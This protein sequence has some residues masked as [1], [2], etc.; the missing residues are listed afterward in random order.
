MPPRPL[1]SIVTPSYNAAEFIE[2]TI[3]S[4][5]AQD[6]PRIEYLVMDGGST[7]GTVEILERYR[8]RLQ[9]VSEKDRG[10]ADAVNRGFRKAR[11]EILAWIG[12]DD[13]YL[14]GAVSAAV[15]A[16]TENP[17][18]GAVYGGGYW[19]DEHG[20]TLGRY[21]TVAP[22]DP[23]MFR[24]ECPI[25]QPAC[26]MRRKAVEAIGGL[27]ES[28]QSAFDY[29][30]WIRLSR[31]HPFRAIPQH[32]AESRMH[33]RNKSLGQKQSMFD[34]CIGLLS[35]HYGYVPMHWVYS[36]V[37]F[38]RDRTDQFFTPMRSSPAAYLRTLVVG[39]RYNV[40]HLPRFWKEWLHGLRD[41]VSSSPAPQTR[42]NRVAID[43]TPMLPGGDNGG[44]KLL[45]LEL[46]RRLA[47]R[48]GAPELVLLTSAKSH[49][50]LAA[51][52]GPNVRRVCVQKSTAE[53]RSR[54]ATRGGK[55]L[56]WFSQR[57]PQRLR[58]SAVNAL[59]HTPS[60]TPLLRQLSADLLFCPFTGISFFDPAVPI[61]AV[62]ADLQYAYYPEFFTPEDRRERQRNF[63]QVCRVASRVVCISEFTRATVLEHSDLPPDRT[64]VI[65]IP[66]RAVSQAPARVPD[67]LP[68]SL[69]RYLLYP[70]NFWRHKN[71]ELLLIA[72]GIYCA[73]HPQPDLKLVLTGA[74]SARRDELIEATGRMGLADRVVFPGFL[75]EEDFAALLAGAAAM[76]FPSLFEGF[77]MPV[78]E[79]MAAGVPVLCANLTSLP[80]V[81]APYAEQQ[82]H[83]DTAL[84]FDPRR[85]AEIVAAI[86]RLES[87]PA[88]RAA[89]IESGRRRAAEF[90]TPD[91][92]AD[93]YW[94]V[95]ED[96]IERP[97]ERSDGVYGVFPDGWTG[98]RLTV[99]FGPEPA[100]RR[101]AIT[102]HA[103]EYLPTSEVDIRVTGCPSGPQTHR[104][105]RGHRQTITLDLPGPAGSLELL[106]MPTFQP[107]GQDLRQLGCLL[108]SAVILGPQSPPE[109]DPPVARELPRE[110][111]AA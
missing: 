59:L 9:F 2:D 46:V 29:D 45:A 15:A 52:D 58:V 1:V 57:L 55:I 19:I 74:P 31:L 4:V 33:R 44:I 80:E 77:G 98:P 105:P 41:S 65:G 106:C 89:L 53:T 67:G 14:P 49:A 30:L 70:A 12:A 25:C 36:Y 34:E 42:L 39:S 27:D 40:R 35:R 76:I 110:V 84:L 17:D 75:A 69:G 23:A 28:L 107:G 91:A 56:S 82:D 6:Y 50:E 16:F 102:L 90:L 81:A 3:R 18:A 93:R 109:G 66:A 64:A 48:P 43:L 86:E 83:P 63:Q 68:L 61:V 95:F 78:L 71:H 85:P 97:V 104:I 47:A 37:S 26:F 32:L 24:R 111:H 54:G 51:L 7:D 21:P 100:P 8:G 60:Q 79:A 72:F 20:R 94:E 22:Y 99:V 38:L 101:L 13:L 103:P 5:L 92:M 11:G 88:L 87:D 96:V 73:A 62:I 10:T 108:E